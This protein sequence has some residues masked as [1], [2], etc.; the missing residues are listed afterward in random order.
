MKNM[1][2][3]LKTCSV[4]ELILI[5]SFILKEFK[6]RG[7]VVKDKEDSKLDAVDYQH[8]ISKNKEL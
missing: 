5:Y 3:E 8:Y 4:E 7:V 1:I 6:L 2:S